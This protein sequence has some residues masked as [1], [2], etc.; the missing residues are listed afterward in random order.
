AALMDLD[1]SQPADWVAPFEQ[2]IAGALAPR[3]FPLQ[4]L[5]VFAALALVLSALGIYGVTAYG[6]T[7]RT[8]E[9]GVRIAIGAQGRDV[10]RMVMWGALKLAAAGGALGVWGAVAGARG[11]VSPPYGAGSPRPP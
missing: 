4:L 6:V 11:V 3:R 8:R 2:R 9:I 10:L 7:Q 1:R 5:G